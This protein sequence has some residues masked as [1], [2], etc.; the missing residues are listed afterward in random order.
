MVKTE[1]T[2]ERLQRGQRETENKEK[3]EQGKQKKHEMEKDGDGRRNKERHCENI[4]EGQEG[5]MMATITKRVGMRV[6]NEPSGMT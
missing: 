2:P 6:G 4:T 5:E 3:G 1:C